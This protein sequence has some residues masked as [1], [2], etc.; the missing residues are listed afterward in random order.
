[1]I[2]PVPTPMAEVVAPAA[3][4]IAE[5]PAA[6]RTGLEPVTG[7]TQKAFTRLLRDVGVFQTTARPKS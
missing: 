1:M 3:V 2:P 5:L 4:S 7:T 6:A